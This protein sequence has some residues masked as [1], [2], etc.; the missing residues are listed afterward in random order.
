MTKIQNSRLLPILFL[1]CSGGAYAQAPA[2]GAAGTFYHQFFTAGGPIVWFVL[3]PMSII[4]VYLAVDLL[5]S[6]RR[7][8]LLPPGAPS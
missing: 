6:I 3:L 4:T 8:R 2:S 5:V 1:I 7:S